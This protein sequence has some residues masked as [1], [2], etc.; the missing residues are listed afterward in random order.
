MRIAVC[1]QW[2]SEFK[3]FAL[4]VDS[5]KKYMVGPRTYHIDSDVIHVWDMKSTNAYD[6]RNV[7][8]YGKKEVDTMSIELLDYDYWI[9]F[10]S[11]IVFREKHLLNMLAINDNI[12]MLPYLLRGSKTHYNVSRVS[13][14]RY[15]HFPIA[16]DGIRS[17]DA[18][19]AGA[20]K[21]SRT[22]FETV[23]P[24]AFCPQQIKS[25]S[26]VRIMSSDYNFCRKARSSGFDI[27]CNFDLPVVHRV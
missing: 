9:Y 22:V 18:G 27:I 11:D 13:A 2:Y 26:M 15:M 24:M 23:E 4:S 21:V 20:L 25:G 12:Y 3:N 7:M 17:V 5:L 16:T 6:G 14:G 10:D 19:G 1:C 8:V